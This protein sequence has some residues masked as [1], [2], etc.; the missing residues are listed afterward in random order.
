VANDATIWIGAM[1]P[2]RGPMAPEF[3]GS[4]RAVDL[5]RR[6]FID[7][8]NG[9]PSARPG[10]PVRPLAVLACDDGEDP[11]RAARHLVDDVGVPAVIGFARSKEVVDLAVDL[12]NPRGVLAL[13]AN[14]ASMI[15]DI[16]RLPGRPRL[17]WRTTISG[18]IIAR[19]MAAVVGTVIEPELRRTRFLGR[20]EPM[21]VALV[22]TDNT[23]GIGLSDSL[24][25]SLRYNGKSV[26][27]NGDA[28]YREMVMADT[29]GRAGR[30]TEDD[31][32]VAQ[33]AAFRPHVV[34]DAAGEVGTLV[35]RLEATWPPAERFRPSYLAQG[36]LSGAELGT[37][38]SRNPE[39]A[40]RLFGV[41]TAIDTPA[42][43]KFVLR[44]N[45]VFSPAI[46]A[47]EASDAPYDAF[48]LLAY[49]IAALGDGPID[50]ASLAR[51]IPRLQGGT[52]VDVG[53]G[54]I[55]AALG[56]LGRGESI[57]LRGTVTSLDF[58]DATGD[59]PASYAVFCFR[60]DSG[61][62]FVPAESGLSFDGKPGQASGELRCP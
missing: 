42:V 32:V 62:H 59:A 46:T 12:F 61:G 44:Y 45:Q 23:S 3:S 17:V 37:S 27:E 52:P 18:P 22:R 57:D 2:T 28:T 41:D 14:T 25:S 26:A 49:A 29:G 55:Y 56:T 39:L 30:I 51:A 60:S 8:S 36:T 38:V 5:A 16:P 31:G 10:G 54:G 7:V 9:L 40:R 58:D 20:D 33:L 34:L 24:V 15:S 1:F 35:A 4:L 47:L 6:D 11:P 53:A 43:A 19:S 50:G 21:R 48:Y 13:A